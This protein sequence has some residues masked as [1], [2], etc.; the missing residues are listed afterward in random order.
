[1]LAGEMQD[2]MKLIYDLQPDSRLF[3]VTKSQLYCAMKRGAAKAGVKKIRIHDLRH[4]HVSL[5]IQQGFTAVDIGNRVGHEAIDIT[6]RYAH[7]FPTTQK[8]MA[9]NLNNARTGGKENERTVSAN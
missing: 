7:M 1:F 6:L 9:E 5:L 4:S 2:Y 3:P 8:Q